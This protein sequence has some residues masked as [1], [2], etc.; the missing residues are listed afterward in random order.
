MRRLKGKNP[1][2]F[3]LFKNLIL[4]HPVFDNAFRLL[5]IFKNQRD[6][7]YQIRIGG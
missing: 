3:A 4:N 7:T 6:A 1:H 5:T 2:I